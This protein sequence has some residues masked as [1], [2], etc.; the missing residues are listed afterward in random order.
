MLINESPRSMAMMMTMLISWLLMHMIHILMRSKISSTRYN[1]GPI[2][3]RYAGTSSI[4]ANVGQGLEPWQH[5]MDIERRHHLPKD[6]HPAHAMDKS[7]PTA[8]FRAVSKLPTHEIT[9]G[10][11]LNRK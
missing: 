10:V 9:G 1:R 11:L 7:G 6:A 4:S 3:I 8:V 5:Q 2:G